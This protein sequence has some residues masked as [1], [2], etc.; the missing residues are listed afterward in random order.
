MAI[1]FVNIG[2]AAAGTTSVATPLPASLRA[3]NALIYPVAHKY[4][5]QPNPVAGWTMLG[6]VVGGAGANGLNS[7]NVRMS[8]M[9]RTVPSEGMSGNQTVT[10]TGG[11]S[12]RARIL[13][14]EKSPNG[15]RFDVAFAVA[16]QNTPGL[17]WAVTAGSDPGVQADDVVLVCSA[18]NGSTASFSA[19][20]LTATGLTVGA[21]TERDEGGT[22]SGDD[23]NVFV[24]EHLIVSGP[25]TDLMNY[26]AIASTTAG[27]HPAGATF[28]IRLREVPADFAGDF[29]GGVADSSPLVAPGVHD[30]FYDA[31]VVLL[32]NPEIVCT[33]EYRMRG[34]DTTLGF[35]VYWTAPTIDFNADSYTGP[36]PVNQI[37]VFKVVCQRPS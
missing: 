29:A 12:G 24:T 25:A 13:Q 11:N 19:Q 2:A 18:V 6:S 23:L 21:E 16:S 26:V 22:T 20:A 32:S 9:F 8:M 3:G 7:G 33:G 5:A 27:N 15:T 31:D 37:S 30:V 10:L 17:A 14:Y 34:F 4:G 36:G 28:F 1:S 35:P